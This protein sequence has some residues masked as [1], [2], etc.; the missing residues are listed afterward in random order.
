M[1]QPGSHPL[2]KFLGY[3]SSE[4]IVSMSARDPFD[5]RG[6]PPN[7][8]DHIST[9]CI[10]G[11][12][13]L[14]S[15]AWQE[16][17]DI[18]NPDAVVPLSDTPFTTPPQSQK[19]LTKSIERSVT[20]LA[21]LLK[22]RAKSQ[23]Y[24]MFNAAPLYHAASNVLLHMAGGVS[25]QARKAFAENLVESL[26]E[27]DIEQLRPFHRLDDG[28]AGYVF[29]LAPLRTAL[30]PGLSSIVRGVSDNLGPQPDLS[31]T[32][33]ELSKL[34]QASLRPLPPNKPRFINSA[35]SPHEMLRLMRDVGIDLFDAHW[36]QRAAD[37]G[38]A[39]DFQFPIPQYPSE[40]ASAGGNIQCAAPK[41]RGGGKFDLGHN[42]YHTCYSHDHSRLASSFLD[43]LSLQGKSDSVAVPEGSHSIC[44]C[45]ACSPIRPSAIVRHS[46]V[47]DL[48]FSD[49]PE[50]P[51]TSQ[52]LPPYARSYIH[53][54]LHTHEMSAHSL[55]VM[56]NLSILDAFLTGVREVLARSDDDKAFI[57]EM[58]KFCDMYDESMVVFDEGRSHWVE[59]E[60]ARGKG[61]LAREK[62]KQAERPSVGTSIET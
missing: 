54:L 51:H 39:L 61:R 34:L 32:P 11:V 2:H 28:V 35:K 48:S 24:Q 50:S 33:S 17:T 25:L 1:L 12:R 49:A 18:C 21:D 8:K 29:D 53:H 57:R 16:Y 3:A 14:S 10:R 5:G 19:R 46:I 7:G 13:K 20:W 31:E 55:L 6:M 42:L 9:Y 26:D 62:V 4:H 43:G 22:Y 37:I 47:D 23:P 44:P 41:V 27:R 58:E 45:G 15:S 52:F 30:S 36:V 60:L 40:S 56:H 59:V 38:I